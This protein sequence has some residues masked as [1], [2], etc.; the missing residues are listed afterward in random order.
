V[1][2]A[3]PSRLLGL[4]KL[5]GGIPGAGG[6]K[7]LN[8]PQKLLVKLQLDLLMNRLIGNNH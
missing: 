2:T 6:R 3:H 1:T 4:G 8:E 5:N 7:K